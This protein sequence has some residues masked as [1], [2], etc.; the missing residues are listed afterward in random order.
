MLYYF[1]RSGSRPARETRFV[2]DETHSAAKRPIS[3]PV[4]SKSVTLQR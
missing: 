3:I 4:K 1:I 2:I